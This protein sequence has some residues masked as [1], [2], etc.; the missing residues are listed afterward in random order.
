MA[1]PSSAGRRC[2]VRRGWCQDQKGREEELSPQVGA[3]D[4]SHVEASPRGT[5]VRRVQTDQKV[6]F[7]LDWAFQDAGK[8]GCSETWKAS[9]QGRCNVERKMGTLGR[10]GRDSCSQPLAG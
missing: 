1:A 10:D 2:G 8:A 7:V 9:M 5:L 4:G 6:G 3:G